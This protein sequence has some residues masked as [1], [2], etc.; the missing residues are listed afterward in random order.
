MPRLHFLHAVP[1]QCLSS[2]E[3]RRQAPLVIQLEQ[4][5]VA[6]RLLDGLAELFLEFCCGPG[7]GTHSSTVALQSQPEACDALCS[8]L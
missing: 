8:L 1:R 7:V 3:V 6:Q 5:G 2:V 4:V